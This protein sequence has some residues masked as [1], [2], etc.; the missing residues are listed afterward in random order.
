M[1]TYSKYSPTGFDSSGAFLPDRQEWLVVSGPFA[2]SN[3]AAALDLLGGEGEDVEVHRFGHWGPGWFEIV[4]VRPGSKSEEVG[5]DIEA[6]LEDYPLLDDEDHSKREWE[7]FLSGWSDY[8]ASDFRRAVCKN[9]EI[10][11]E[12]LDDLDDDK[13]REFYCDRA[14]EAYFSEDSGVCIPVTAWVEKMKEK[15]FE[16]L[17]ILVSG[18]SLKENPN[19]LKLTLAGEAE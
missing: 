5:N 11:E 9:F 12:E 4:I 19:Q 15:D 8:G 13:L 17:M 14:N 1:Q 2:E 3:F 6:R 18:G 16:D 7:E 10:T